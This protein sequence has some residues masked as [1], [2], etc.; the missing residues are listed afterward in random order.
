MD[1]EIRKEI[2]KMTL[3]NAFEHGGKTQEKIILGKIL[4]TKPEFRT[5]VK[6]ISVEI[7]E[8][9]SNVNQ[10]SIKEQKKRN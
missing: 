7:A 6:E 10:L 5:K 8:I 1:E 2:R 3:Q 9:V 4:G